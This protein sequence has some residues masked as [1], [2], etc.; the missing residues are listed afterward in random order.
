MIDLSIVIIN[1]NSE[2]Y[3]EECLGSCIAQNTEFIYEIIVVD[4]F[5]TDNSYSKIKT[6]K[7]K[8]VRIFRNKKNL[9]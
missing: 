1:F 5:S 8:L 6:Y 2:K 9:G 3:I 7:S 4:D